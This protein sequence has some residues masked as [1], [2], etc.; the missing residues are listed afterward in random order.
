MELTIDAIARAVGR[1]LAEVRVENLV[2]AEAM[3]YTNVAGKFYDTGDYPA[4]VHQAARMIDLE[5]IR[6]R[7]AVGEPDGR[8]V[9][10]GFSTFTEQ[11]AHGTKVFG[12][13]GLP[14]V[15]GYEQAMVKLAPS[16][17]LEVRSGNHSFGQGLETTIAQVASEQLGTPIQNIRVKMGDTGETPYSTGAY[18]SRG[19]V[20]AGGAVSKASETLA[21]RIREHAAH[22]LQCHAD[23]VTLADGHAH[24]GNASVTF[25]EIARAWYLR[26]DQLAE[27]V[28]TLGLEVTEGYKPEIDT[29]FTYATHAAMVAVDPDTGEVEILD[30]VLFEDC[31]TRVNPLILEGQSHGG[32]AQGIGSALFEESL[33]DSNGQ[34]LTT[35][36]ADYTIPGPTELPVPDRTRRVTIAIHTARCQGIRAPPSHQRAPWSTP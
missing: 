26:P 3:P 35:T 24:S 25:K 21:V 28:N 27:D 2:P 5:S 23:D 7:Q 14:L 10:L 13:W 9:G 15:P 16:G 4:S 36:F 12:A 11:T 32:T 31:G 22:L 18:A 1:E 6:K 19:M 20:M 34:P 17:T 29:V 8:L 30:Y 33:Y